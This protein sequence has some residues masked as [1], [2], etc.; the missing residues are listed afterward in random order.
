MLKQQVNKRLTR[1]V[2]CLLLPLACPSILLAWEGKVVGVTDGDTIKV[3]QDGKQVKIR[4]VAIDCPEK[5][6]PYGQADALLVIFG[7]PQAMTDQAERAI[8]CSI[9]MQNA[10]AEGLD[11][12][13]PAMVI[14]K[15]VWESLK[16]THKWRIVE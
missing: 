1:F 14:I 8:A 13:N 12:S 7:A 3:L 16:G 4:L 9:E 6:Q 15:R 11:E 5:G 2:F 10:M